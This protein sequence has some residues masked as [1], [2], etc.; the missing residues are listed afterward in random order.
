MEGVNNMAKI[1]YRL[2]KEGRYTIEQVP[3]RWRKDVEK[4]LEADNKNS[5]EK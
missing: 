3:A 4:M 1:Y 2:I 5:L